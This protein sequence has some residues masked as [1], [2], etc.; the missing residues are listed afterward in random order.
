[1]MT[2]QVSS[3]RIYVNDKDGKLIVE[4]T[5]PLYKEGVVVVN[6]TYVDPSLRGQGIASE[7]MKKVCEKVKEDD[8]KVIAT[9]PY[10]VVWF[11]RH[12]DYDDLIDHEAQ[13]EVSPECTI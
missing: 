4:A 2:Y 13:A 3:H 12:K 10:A 11:K 6:H 8:M 1:M 9:C 5:F 7:L